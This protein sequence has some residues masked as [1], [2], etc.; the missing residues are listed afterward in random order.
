MNTHGWR[1]ILQRW[2]W[3]IVL[4]LS[5]THVAL[6]IAATRS[7]SIAYDELLHIT[8]GVTA[9]QRHDYRLLPANGNLPQRV[10]GLPVVLMGCQLPPAND[11]AWRESYDA[12]VGDQFFFES[13]NDP[14]TMLTAARA[15]SSVWGLMLCLVVWGWSRSIFGRDGGLLSLTLAAFWPAVLAHGPLATSDVCGAAWFTLAAWMLWNLLHHVS[16]ARVALS[17]LTIG[18][19]LVAKHSA[20]LLLPVGLLMA[21]LTLAVNRP[22]RVSCGAGHW[23]LTSRLFRLAVLVT[24]PLLLLPMVL[25]VI[26]AFFGFRYAV[27]SPA[28]LPQLFPAYPT[29]AD[30]AQAAGSLGRLCQWLGE[31][32]LLP[33]GWLYG[34]LHVVLFSRF[35]NAFALGLY[36]QTGWWWYFP[37]CLAVKNTLPSLVLLATGWLRPLVWR[38]TRS[39]YA[40]LPLL[41]MQ[42]VLWP[43]FL[44]SHLNIGERHILPAYPALIILA[45][46]CWGLVPRSSPVWRRRWQ[47]LVL[48]LV[49]LHVADTACRYP[50]FFSYFNQI[51]PP[52]QAHRW[53][54]D[55]NLDWGQEM[56]GLAIWLQ[57]HRRESEPVYIDCFGVERPDVYGVVGTQLGRPGGD[58]RP[59]QLQPGLFCISAT[60][61]MSV[62]DD[63][64]GPWCEKFERAYWSLCHTPADRFNLETASV[65]SQLQ[66]AR[67]KAF[68]RKRSPTATIAGAILIFRLSAHDLSTALNGRPAELKPQ[69]WIELESL[70]Q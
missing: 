46:G 12:I 18:L 52:R 13:G 43:V 26:Y 8:G 24:L 45:G 54:I 30:A 55:S 32:R 34:L 47:W 53:L 17:G 23:C 19:A 63:P 20:V 3:L 67:L 59:Q 48:A 39:G 42:I 10:C 35:R 37:L 65:L 9:W 1:C 4:A 66:A 33:E 58:G 56:P 27:A 11:R 15:A 38:R 22:L 21:G 44:S 49:G 28:Y 14:L 50:H 2:E 7:K 36:S 5:I 29:L 70:R 57:Q 61:L 16:L 51:V 62:Y 40:C 6:A 41:V 31:W 69:S 25:V 60:S 68:L 64:V